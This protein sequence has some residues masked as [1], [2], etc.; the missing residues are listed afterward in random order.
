MAPEMMASQ[1]S[2]WRVAL[3]DPMQQWS[4]SD[5]PSFGDSEI[6]GVEV[7]A[8]EV[9]SMAQRD[10]TRGPRATEWIENGARPD[11]G[12]GGATHTSRLPS[13]RD[14][15]GGDPPVAHPVGTDLPCLVVCPC[16][17]D[18]RRAVEQALALDA[19]PPRGPTLHGNFFKIFTKFCGDFFRIK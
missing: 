11:S 7:N 2:W 10:H 1:A 5:D 4:I 16:A 6:L 3:R 8:N 18:R 13:T 9:P 17:G 12:R 14:D 19:A 15:V